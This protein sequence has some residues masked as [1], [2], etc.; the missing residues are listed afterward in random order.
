LNPIGDVRDIVA[1]GKKV[2][3]GDGKATIPLIAS[4]VGAIPGGGD[5]AKPIIKE[6]GEELTEKAV[7]EVGGETVEKVAKEEVP[8]VVKQTGKLEIEPGRTFTEAEKRFAEKEVADGKHVVARKESNEY[9]VKSPDFEING[10][11][12]EFKYISDLKGIDADS[13]SS[14]LSRR[15]LDGGSQASK[16]SLDVSDQTGMTREIAERAIKRAY[17]N[18][19]RRASESI[20]EVRVYG[21]GFD[22]TIPFSPAKKL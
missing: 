19:D 9:K 1:N 20:K 13:L 17:G 15:I 11:I 14:G 2:I 10:E 22:I 6:V 16:I 18:L 5:V 21:K 4:V 12:V 3:G 7:K 8:P